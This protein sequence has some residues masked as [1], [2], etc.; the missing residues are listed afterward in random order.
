MG[1]FH[2]MGLSTMMSGCVAGIRPGKKDRLCSDKT[3]MGWKSREI[4]KELKHES[5]IALGK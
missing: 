2:D 5:H 3:G 1:K 4:K